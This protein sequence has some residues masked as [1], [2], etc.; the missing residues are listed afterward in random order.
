[1]A[2]VSVRG[3]GLG[4]LLLVLSTLAYVAGW[5]RGRRTGGVTAPWLGVALIL[6]VLSILARATAWS[7]QPC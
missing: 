7:C 6:F 2:W 1:M 5:E 3:T 4:G